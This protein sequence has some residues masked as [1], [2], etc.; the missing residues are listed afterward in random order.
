MS[1]EQ[2]WV[3]INVDIYEGNIVIKHHHYHHNI[4]YIAVL[5]TRGTAVKQ[6]T[7][8]WTDRM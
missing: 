1:L 3:M 5:V 8:E 6:K 2:D 4:S 7:K